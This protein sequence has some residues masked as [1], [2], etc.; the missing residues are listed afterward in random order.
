MGGVKTEGL[1]RISG[2]EQSQ[3]ERQRAASERLAGLSEADRAWYQD[4]VKKGL[5][6]FSPGIEFYS[7]IA[8]GDRAARTAAAAPIVSEISKGAQTA[9]ER[10]YGEVPRGAGQEFALATVPR[11]Q[12]GAVAKAMG[13]TYLSS[14]DKLAGYGQGVASVGEGVGQYSLAEMAGGLRASEAASTSLRGAGMS[15]RDIAEAKAK[16]KQSTM[17]FLGDIVKMAGGLP[18]GKIFG[19]GGGGGGGEGRGGS[20][21]RLPS[22][23]DRQLP[24]PDPG[25]VIVNPPG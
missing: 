3:A 25:P 22:W 18:W 15:E 13:E 2:L 10:I 23:R 21:V 24:G 5:D 7:R 14:F 19:V 11:E 12:A 1:E 9:K 16:K 17:G 20:G 6:L 4:L 8:S